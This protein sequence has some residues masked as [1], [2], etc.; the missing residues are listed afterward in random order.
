M[1]STVAENGPPGGKA[2]GLKL[3]A[4]ETS[5]LPDL[6]EVSQDFQAHMKSMDGMKNVG[7]SSTETPGQFVF[8]LKKDLLADYGVSP[9]VI[10]SAVT[11][12]MNGVTVG[13]VENNGSDMD[14]ILKTDTFLS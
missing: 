2:V 4:E 13:T 3:V 6:I 7:T 10:Y 11:Q 14:V 1:T 5:D 8:S 12:N 9:S